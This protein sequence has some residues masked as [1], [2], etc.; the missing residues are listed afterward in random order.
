M[1]P[2][3]FSGVWGSVYKGF[4]DFGPAASERLWEEALRS[5]RVN[6]TVN[7]SGYP[8][9]ASSRT[10]REPTLPAFIQIHPHA[11]LCFN[12]RG[13]V[14]AKT[15]VCKGVRHKH[16]GLYMNAQRH[17]FDSW[18]DLFDR[19]TLNILAIH[20]QQGI[21]D[22]NER[23]LRRST[24]RMQLHDLEHTL[25]VGFQERTDT[26]QAIAACSPTPNHFACARW[27]AR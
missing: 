24:T 12:L 18:G 23:A 16:V 9:R 27:S 6:S 10:T 1:G 3:G 25:G 20:R 21:S 8:R 22:R 15:H 26:Y 13:K 14:Y 19:K 17:T 4:G 11:H 7:G 5:M 2:M